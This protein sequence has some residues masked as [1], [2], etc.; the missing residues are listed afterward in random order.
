MGHLQKCPQILENQHFKKLRQVKYITKEMNNLLLAVKKTM[1]RNLDKATIKR[2]QNNKK[3]ET[4][5]LHFQTAKKEKF[6]PLKD[7][8]K[9]KKRKE[10]KASSKRIQIQCPLN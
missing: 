8:K 10:M 6:V 1:K 5:H 9:R 3:K 4:I 2:N 7:Q